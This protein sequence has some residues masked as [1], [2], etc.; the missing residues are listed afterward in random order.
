MEPITSLTYT[1]TWFF[2]YYIGSDFC[3][4]IKYSREFTT[5]NE[6]LDKIEQQLNHI[7][8]DF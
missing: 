6:K 5:I 4:Y 7:V 3:N 8:E 1:L 2:G